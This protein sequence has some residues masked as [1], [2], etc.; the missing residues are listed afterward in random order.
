MNTEIEVIEKMNP[1]ELFQEDKLDPVL[2]A[3]EKEVTSEVPDVTTGK[4]RDRIKALA[5]KVARTKTTLDGMGKDLVADWKTKA[6][7]VDA[8]R[9]HAREFLDALK[10]KVRRPVTEWEQAEAKRVE[11]IET[12]I[13]GIVIARVSIN[14]END[15]LSVDELKAKLI[16][17]KALKIDKWL[18]EYANV[19]ARE[20]DLTVSKLEEAIV[21]QEERE[22]AV[23]ELE[24]LR[25]EAIERELRDEKERIAKEAEEKAEAAAKE[26][27]DAVIREAEEKLAAAEREAAEAEQRLID[28]QEASAREAVEAEQRRV[29]QLE[30]AKREQREAIAAEQQRVKD[31]K[32]LEEQEK[33]RREANLTHRK[34]INNEA[35]KCFQKGGLSKADSQLA[36]ELI[37]KKLVAHISINY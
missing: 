29:D 15:Y 3:I 2:K 8:S 12:F 9:K 33:S 37:A 21:R 23:A 34:K 35:L 26:K 30:A 1:V 20:K 7:L 36:V 4:G 27:V 25:A 11:D 14:E 28:R 31:E 18:E 6:K 16:I 5:H 13:E 19:A 24:R 22:A 32:I 10:E 17:V